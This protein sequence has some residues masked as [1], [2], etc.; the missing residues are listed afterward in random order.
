MDYDHGTRTPMDCRAGTAALLSLMISMNAA[1]LP[2]S[3]EQGQKPPEPSVNRPV[4]PKATDRDLRTLPPSAT[5]KPG[6][7]VREV[8]DLRRS[9]PV[10]ASRPGEPRSPQIFTTDLRRLAPVESRRRTKTARKGRTVDRRYAIRP[11]N[12]GFVVSDDRG[13]VVGPVPFAAFWGSGPCRVRSD[14]SPSVLND[15][16]A[17]RWLLSRWAAPTPGSPFH[18]CVALSRSSDPVTG[19]WSLYEFP[20]PVYRADA[21]M[22]MRP[23]GYRL[24]V[25]ASGAQ[26]FFVFD[27]SGMLRGGP[28][29]YT[30]TS[31]SEKGRSP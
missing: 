14:L 6:D 5:W 18:F 13:L 3:Q 20:L 11:A 16:T 2:A 8:P 30:Q 22:E 15:R 31:T 4:T 12:G 7:P 25:G 19:G 21:Q 9:E 27:R 24:R 10:E 28:A 1:T 23:D 29:G 26:T 17:G